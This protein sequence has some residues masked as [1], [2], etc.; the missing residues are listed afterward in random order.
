MGTYFD[1]CSDERIENGNDA[2]LKR[3]TRRRA[4][5]NAYELV[6]S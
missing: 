2:I 4:I 3:L 6:Q 1:G 5:G